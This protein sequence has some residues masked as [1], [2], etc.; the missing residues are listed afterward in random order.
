LGTLHKLLD[1]ENPDDPQ[2]ESVAFVRQ[3]LIEAIADTRK[4]PR[5]LSNRL[6]SEG[7][8]SFR[9]A[10]P[11]ARQKLIEQWTAV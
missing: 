2:K 9:H 8:K 4:G 5:D 10:S 11:E 6:D 1:I 7:A 3:E